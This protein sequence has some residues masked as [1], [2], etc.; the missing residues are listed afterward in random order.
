MTIVTSCPCHEGPPATRGHRTGSIRLLASGGM[1]S[2]QGAVLQLGIFLRV[3]PPALTVLRPARTPLR[4]ARFTY[5]PARFE[6]NIYIFFIF[7]SYTNFCFCVFRQLKNCTMLAE[8]F[9][10]IAHKIV[11]RSCVVRVLDFGRSL[12]KVCPTR[13]FTL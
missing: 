11:P 2:G 4:P 1:A 3:L 5:R 6:K 10:S 13:S 12:A 9:S 7:T 8:M